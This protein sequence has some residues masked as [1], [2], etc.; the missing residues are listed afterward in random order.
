MALVNP[1]ADFTAMGVVELIGGVD[2]IG[3]ERR[4]EKKIGEERQYEKQGEVGLEVGVP[5]I[6]KK[7]SFHTERV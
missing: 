4:K 7:R 6:F 5:G 2:V 3:G 1:P